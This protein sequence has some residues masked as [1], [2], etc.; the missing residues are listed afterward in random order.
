MASFE[1]VKIMSQVPNSKNKPKDKGKPKGRPRKKAQGDT[2]SQPSKTPEPWE[3][4]PWDTNASYAAFHNY[5]LVLET[6]KRSTARAYRHYRQDHGHTPKGRGRQ[7]NAQW[8]KWAAGLNYR[9]KKP[10]GSAYENSL[11]W[12]ERAAAYDAVVFAKQRDTWEARREKIRQREYDLGD[13]LYERVLKM[14]D[15][16]LFTKTEDG[17]MVTIQPAKWGELDIQRAMDMASQL[18]RRGAG[19]PKD[20]TGVVVE[21]A[22]EMKEKGLDPDQLYADLVASIV[23][24][25]TGED[26]QNEEDKEDA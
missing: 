3:R 12:A 4:Q 6:E 24:Q 21:W 20:T 25:R 22:D 5:Y 15:A 19:M 14:L 1:K 16:V 23:A 11:T 13:K 9:G 17:G 7:A 2:S 26:R 18:M 10:K 8:T